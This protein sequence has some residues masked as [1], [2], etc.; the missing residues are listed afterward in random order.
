VP[1]HVPYC[2]CLTW[3]VLAVELNKADALAL[4]S[5][6]FESNAAVATWSDS[7]TIDS[8]V[9]YKGKFTYKA[10]S[11]TNADKENIYV[12]FP[13]GI[14]QDGSYCWIFSTFTKTHTG[15][16]KVPIVVKSQPEFNGAKT[17]FTIHTDYYTWKGFT[18]D[19]WKTVTIECWHEESRRSSDLVALV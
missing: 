19:D 13:T 10:G 3:S 12:T 14:H 18:T 1:S 8:S 5:I 15:S 6:D 11:E 16:L 2:Y 7:T 17:S 4:G 9:S